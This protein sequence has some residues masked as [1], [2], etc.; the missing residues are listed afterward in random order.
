MFFGYCFLTDGTYAP[1]ITLP[2]AGDAFAYCRLHSRLFAEVL[3]TDADDYVVMQARQ[4]IVKIPTLSGS[5]DYVHLLEERPV[6]AEER[7]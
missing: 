1:K 5:F 7:W 3:I 4:G 6:L 2:T